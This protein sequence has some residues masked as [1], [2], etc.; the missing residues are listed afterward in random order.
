MTVYEAIQK[1]AKYNPDTKLGFVFNG[2]VGLE[3][4]DTDQMIVGKTEIPII[5][6]F[7]EID[8]EHNEVIIEFGNIKGD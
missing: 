5:F 2:L 8:T 4:E 1:L 7:D 6:K 3:Y